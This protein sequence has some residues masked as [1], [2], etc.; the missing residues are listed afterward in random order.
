[1]T[2]PLAEFG[3]IAA[4]GP[5]KVVELVAKLRSGETRKIPEI[6]R[7]GLLALAA[8]LDSLRSSDRDLVRGIRCA[9]L[10]FIKASG[11]MHRANRPDT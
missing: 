10:R 3:N 2:P 6:A 8:Q 11:H 7:V 5:S 1:M 9:D 4:Q